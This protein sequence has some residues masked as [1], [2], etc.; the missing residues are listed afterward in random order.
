MRKKTNRPVT[1]TAKTLTKDSFEN[2]TLALGR[3]VSTVGKGTYV[4]SN[5]PKYNQQLLENLYEE[6]WLAKACI[7][8]IAKD[9]TQAGIVINSPDSPEDITLIQAAMTDLKLLASLCSAIKWARLYG[10]AAAYL[11]IDGQ[12][13]STELKLATVGRNQFKGIRVYNRWQLRPSTENLIT[14]LCPEEGEPKFYNVMGG[15]GMKEV[16]FKIHHTRIIKLVGNELPYFKKIA[17]LGWGSSVLAPIYDRILYAD[18]IA[19]TIADCATR[20]SFRVLKV[21]DYR[22]LVAIGGAPLEGFLA[23]VKTMVAIQSTQGISVIDGEDSLEVLNIETREL[24]DQKKGLIQEIAGAMGIPMSRFASEAVGGF[25]SGD[26][27]LTLYYETILAEQEHQLRSGMAK[28]INLLYQSIL[29]RPAEGMTFTFNPVR[30]EISTKEEK[31]GNVIE[32]KK[33]GI[34]GNEEA[35]KELKEGEGFSNVE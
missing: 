18:T 34:I 9:M 10:G 22:Q 21:K 8:P 26:S 13:P 11:L 19:A 27:E 33:E 5:N 24:D 28:I 4:N 31:V 35:R 16:S 23:M 2:M 25:S 17:A 3:S 7:D 14:D 32:A 1:P 15:L 6:S 12:D 30:K 20:S 29:N